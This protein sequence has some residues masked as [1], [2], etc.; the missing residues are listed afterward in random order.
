[1]INMDNKL[2]IFFILFG[3]LSNAQNR[4]KYS[5]E[6][7]NIGVDAKS[8]GMGNAV[9]SSID[10]VNATYWNPAGL[11]NIERE[12]ISLM[13]SNYF[14]NIANYNYM[15]YAKKI[16]SESAI[17]LSLIRFGV[18][19]IMD[20]TQLIDSQGNIDYNRI[21]L[22]SAADYAF[23]FS[24]AK[25]NKFLNL[26][27]GVNAKIIRRIIGDF[28]NSWGF[29]FDFGI[30][31]ESENKW[32]F[33]LMARDITTTYNSWTFDED[34][35][36]D[37]QNALEGEN[38]EIPE[39]NEISIPKIQLGI[40][41]EIYI[42]NEYSLLTAFDLF[43]VFEETNDLISTSFASINPSIGFEFDYIKLVYL[44]LGLGNFQNE[45]QF[46]ST[47]ELSFQPNF[48]IGFNLGNIEVDY[49][50][51]DIGNQSAALYSNIFSL[52][53]NLDLLR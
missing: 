8:I 18:D 21:E 17:G 15:S 29:G 3:L 27:F 11:I 41:K 6:F 5:N 51:T 52:K 26:N 20:T 25:K 7:L 2:L 30:Q 13:H 38:Q 40:S 16:D 46:D 28:A 35:L 4:S 45:I 32:K 49:A 9:V 31:Y 37:I 50:F 33:G 48:G 10:D 23:I 1:M 14:A 22:F 42:N 24:Y 44:R 19:D 36:N 47:T 39:K 34:K 43:M 12:E 53:F